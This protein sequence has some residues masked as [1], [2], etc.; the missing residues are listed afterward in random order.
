[1]SKEI[2]SPI[3]TDKA[4][5]AAPEKLIREQLEYFGIDKG[6]EL[7]DQFR[8]LL[9]NIY[10]SQTHIE[11]IWSFA[12]DYLLNADH[13]DKIALFNA[14]RFICF[15]LAKLLDTL[16]NPLRKEFRELRASETTQLAKGPYA[17]FD[18]IPAIFSSQP[19]IVKTATYIYS[20]IDWI[21]DAFQGKEF[22]HSIYSRLLNPTSI[23]LANYI[24][25]LECGHEAD[26]YMALNFNSGFH[27]DEFI[28]FKIF[29]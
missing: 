12:T 19:V 29:I 5:D 16:Q 3:R 22:L 21:R 20:C 8:P 28:G 6:T 1:M 15:Q 18:N 11:N 17:M 2:L 23:S 13:K 9:G 4:Q 10:N 27:L 24:V 25:E 26:K 7:Y 14:K